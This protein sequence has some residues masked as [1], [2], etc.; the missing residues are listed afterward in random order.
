MRRRMR[1][2]GLG[3]IAATII[4]VGLPMFPAQAQA[5]PWP[6]GY[7]SSGSPVTTGHGGAGSKGGA[8]PAMT[9]TAGPMTSQLTGQLAAMRIATAKYSTDLSRAKADGYR[10]ITKMMPNMGFHFMNPSI[11]GFDIRKPQIL[12][13][14]HAAG[15]WQLGALEWVFTKMPKT[16]P[17]PNATFGSFPAACHFS[18]GTFLPDENSKT[19]PTKAPH[20][21]ARFTFWHP[22]LITM[23]VWIW[24]PNP[25]GLYSSTNPLVSAFNRG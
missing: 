23:H 1:M 10:I 9:M 3:G 15:K 16:V 12:V 19:C 7:G 11:A 2:A 24:Y 21:G 18:D 6:S 22:D 4:A 20:T 5:M 13:Y 25:A 14:E 8:D 17:L